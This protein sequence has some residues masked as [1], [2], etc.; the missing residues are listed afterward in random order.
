MRSSLT[1]LLVETARIAP[2]VVF[3]CDL[4]G[5]QEAS[6]AA[7]PQH[8]AHQASSTV[9]ARPWHCHG[10]TPQQTAAEALEELARWPCGLQTCMEV[11]EV[12]VR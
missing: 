6:G 9:A 5:S 3:R 11:H 12:H 1:H 8:P 4:T 10:R 7:S 2:E